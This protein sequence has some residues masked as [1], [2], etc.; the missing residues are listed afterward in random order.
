MCLIHPL[1]RW[2]VC[3]VRNCVYALT[4]LSVK[5]AVRPAVARAPELRRIFVLLL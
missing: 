5:H 3:V 2:E 4:G 1:C